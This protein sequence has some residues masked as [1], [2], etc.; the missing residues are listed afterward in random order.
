MTGDKCRGAEV[1]NDEFV[2]G[3]Q[4]LDKVIGLLSR[5]EVVLA[6]ELDDSRAWP[7]VCDSNRVRGG[8]P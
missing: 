6:T 7:R 5:G 2:L 3:H 8:N 4:A 1:D